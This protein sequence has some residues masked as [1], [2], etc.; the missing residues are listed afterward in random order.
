MFTEG[1][2]GAMH[3]ALNSPVGGRNNLW[4]QSN[5]VLTGTEPGHVVQACAPK[6]DFDLR[7]RQ[8]CA[9]SSLGFKDAS[10]RGVVSQRTWYFPG[11]TPSAD[12][13]AVP[14]VTYSTPG[15]Y[16]VILVVTNANGSDSLVRQGLISVVATPGQTAVPYSESFETIAFPGTDWFI[17]NPDQNNTWSLTTISGAT[18]TRSVRIVNQ[19]GNA[20]G[21]VDALISPTFNLSNSFGTQLGFKT[22]FAA[23]NNNDSSIL[24]V[25]VS[26]N[27]GN[28]WL[29]RL[30]KTGPALRTASN[31]TGP[32]FPSSTQWSNEQ[33]NLSSTLFSGRPS[34]MLKFEF[35]N[36]QG[37][38]FYLD[39]I[40][41]SSTVSLSEVNAYRYNIELYPNPAAETMHLQMNVEAGITYSW[42]LTNASGICMQ[43]STRRISSGALIQEAIGNELPAG[44]YLLRLNIGDDVITR[45]VVFIR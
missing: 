42:S 10:W 29:L 12:T 2:K 34:I 22:A 39:D 27:C 24:K 8:I 14:T 36:D 13:S 9:G 20:T 1:Q 35:T 7:K 41:L 3:A 26:N 31:T 28:T 11:G 18:G 16:D 38:N 6:A 23:K 4:Q 32:F 37:N 19:S 25:Y 43:E 17:E 15:L 5:L 44:F 45:R 40:N 30:T 21:S 33:I